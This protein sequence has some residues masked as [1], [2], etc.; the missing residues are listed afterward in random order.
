MARLPIL[1]DDSLDKKTLDTLHEYEQKNGI[2]SPLHRVLANNPAMFTLFDGYIG[3]IKREFSLGAA[4][5]KLIILLI[6]S[7]RKCEYCYTLHR[8]AALKEF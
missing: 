2:D 7:I 1:C 8:K 3:D 4:T 5:E 6:A